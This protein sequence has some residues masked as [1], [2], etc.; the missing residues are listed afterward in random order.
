[1]NAMQA[2][3]KQI[4]A[5]HLADEYRV[6]NA[7][8]AEAPVS[9]D[10][11][12]NMVTAATDI[13]T[14]LRAEDDTSVMSRFLG[15]Y[16]LS[17]E[18]GLALMTLAEALLRVPDQ[19]TVSDLIEDKITGAAWA[20]HLGKSESLLVN[21]STRALLLSSQVLSEPL[22]TDMAGGLQ[23]AIK[24]LGEP[25]I[26]RAIKQAMVELG[27]QFVLGETVDEAIS[28][29]VALQKLGYHYSYDMLG[30]AALTQTDAD[31]YF[32]A[33]K[34][35]IV[36]LSASSTN[37]LCRDN[38][39][40]SVK[41]SAL[42]PRYESTQSERVL[43]E[44][45]PRLNTL[46]RLAC[47]ANMGF[48]VD[49]EEA[50][51]LDLS[52]DVIAAVFA[53]SEL[54][55]R[56]GFGVVVQAYGKRCA[57]VIDW[58]YALAEKHDRR[59][60]VRL[61]KGAYWDSEIKQA[62]VLGASDYP[63]FSFKQATDVAYICCARK[64]LDRVDR[65]YPQFA[66][67][68]AHTVAAV[69]EL[70]AVDTEHFEFQRLH[71]MGEQ[72]HEL[73]R[74]RFDTRCRIYAP[75]GAHRDLLAYLV[76]RLLEN[77][78][79]SSFVNQL[80]D[81]SIAVADISA[82]PFLQISADAEQSEH[83]RLIKPSEI[84]ATERQ[85]SSGWDVT[86]ESDQTLL[87]NAFQQYEKAQ[88]SAHPLTVAAQKRL[89]EISITNPS[90]PKDT[91]GSVRWADMACV[92]NAIESA[93]PW[94]CASAV[95]RAEVLIE[96]SILLE[97]QHGEIFALLIREAGKTPMDAI[98]ELR[99][100]VDFLRYYANEAK[101]YPDYKPRGVIACISPWNFPLAIFTGQIAAALA[102]GNAVIAKPADPTPLIA[103][104]AVQC[105]HAAGVPLAAL[106]FLPGGAAVGQ[107]IT[108]DRRIGGVCFT[109][110]TA[111]AR[112]INRQMAEAL[113]PDAPLIAETGGINAMIVDSTALPEQA[114]RDIV[115]SAFQSAGQRCSALRVV[116]VQEDVAL[117]FRE[118]LDG[119]I[120]ELVV[121]APQNLTTDVGPIINSGALDRL[122][123][124]LIQRQNQGLRVCQWP[125]SDTLLGHYLPPTVVDVD[126][127]EQVDTEV[128]GPVLHFLS[129]K[130]SELD[131]LI[132]D[133]NASG[134]GLTF[135][136]HTRM[137][138]RVDHVVSR[139]SAG[140]VYVNRN[141][142]GAV[143]ESQPFGGEGLSG[144]GPKA[145]GPRYVKRFCKMPDVP[146]S[147][148]SD[149]AA[150]EAM[151]I[152]TIQSRIDEL[153]VNAGRLNRQTMPG[154]TGEHNELSEYPR[155]VVLCLGPGKQLS[156]QQ[157]DLA[158]ST[159]CATLI[160][161]LDDIS[162]LSQLRGVA[163]VICCDDT[164]QLQRIRRA[165]ANIDGPLVPLISNL[166]E[167]AERC[168]LERHVCIDTTAA[169]GNASLLADY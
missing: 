147:G 98:A 18:E 29:G 12:R 139:I 4:R 151:P 51:R 32:T 45:V 168:V 127:F 96:A 7:M 90:D 59:L 112:S 8:M 35:A 97:E 101:R 134:Y 34:E 11:R 153:T 111:V 23:S 131:A 24:R 156:Q 162:Q 83:R 42:H 66:T 52:L 28:N 110:S 55:G 152:E 62:Q 5:N 2:A 13:V 44:L 16:G 50:N 124:Y 93:L 10:Q 67:H 123:D 103:F 20:E 49:A 58:L 22:S 126:R 87:I 166:S 79:N 94:T 125:V 68:N 142:I 86:N 65:L 43:K 82:D 31:A 53:D 136:L 64:L 6:I 113:D 39:G 77:G 88:W 140:N 143:V 89:D 108:A 141:Q 160:A 92:S 105:L 157:S 164:A 63:V 155:G 48:N 36:K 60:M 19:Q 169:G 78:A 74:E 114:I 84:Y 69:M 81:K 119:T 100:A 120:K 121:G 27:K 158:R 132:D 15:Q 75:V 73:I 144:T 130:L 165:L 91:V 26:R 161:G 46:A 85:N 40:I 38:P 70:S 76:R 102:T 133:I 99:E 109:G 54:A 135:G 167:V 25:I 106:Q 150:I 3:R 56:N 115:V 41:L 122:R 95:E 117:S 159:G 163:A 33:Y 146:S 37:K 57:Y 107:S 72:L 14:T 30:E 21:F 148:V 116:C 138:T 128:F 104:R 71:G 149:E 145:G 9:A 1:M 17:T 137:Q 129:F 118:M 61:V 80:T 47:R 154:P